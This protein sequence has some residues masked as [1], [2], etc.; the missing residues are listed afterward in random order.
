M[1]TIEQQL[2]LEQTM[3]DSG[4]SRYMKAQREAEQEG[5]GHELDYSRRLMQEFIMPL[6]EALD[7]WRNKKGASRFGRARGLLEHTS[8]EIAMFIA[9]RCMFSGFTRESSVVD[10]ANTIGKM[11]ED[12]VRFTLF[13]QQFGDY[14][15]RIIEDF[16]RKGT[17][18][19]RYMHRV[20]THK[21]NEKQLEWQPWSPV[22]RV[23]VGTKLLNIIVENSDL[24]KRVDRKYKM[25]NIV[26]LVPTDAAVKFIHEHEAI[27][28]FLYPDRAPCIIEPDPWIGVNQGGYYSAHLRQNVKAIQ[29]RHMRRIRAYAQ[30]KGKPLTEQLS[31]VFDSLNKAQSVPWEV[32]TEVLDVVRIV[33]ARNLQIGMPPTEKIEPRES[34][35]KGRDQS[36]FTEEEKMLFQEWKWEANAAYTAEKERISK[37]FQV[38]RIIKLANDYSKYNA[39]WYVWYS[40]FR[41]RLY[42]A[43]AGFSPQ[44]PDIGKGLIRFNRAKPLGT[45]EGVYWFYVHGANRYGYDKATYDNRVRWVR[46]RH[47]AFIRA[48]AD[49]L[50]HRDV[51]GSADKPWQFLAWLFEYKAMHDMV[52]LG[53]PMQQFRT[54]L[55]VGLD[56]SCNGLQNFSAMLRD[57][58]G[59]RA[60][61]LAPTEDPNDIYAE[62]AEV[63]IRKVRAKYEAATEWS[64][65]VGLDDKELEEAVREHEK[66]VLYAK[67][68]LDWGIDRKVCKRPVMTM[69]YGSTRQ[70]C[71]QYI[72]A[73]VLAKDREYFGVGHG[74]RAACWI[75][76][77]MW[78][79]IGEV[80]V[81]AR[82]AMTW[83][84]KAATSM[85][86]A[87]LPLAWTC[88]DGFIVY[89]R[90][91]EIETVQIDTQL[92]G[93]FQ[94]RVGNYTDRIDHHKQRSGV[95]PNFVHS[96]DATHLRCTI[97]KAWEYGIRDMS[98]IHDDY[99]CHA[100]DIPLLHKAIREAFVELYAN[101]DPL[102]E[103]MDEQ[104]EAGGLLQSLPAMGAFNI[105]DVLE[106]KY[107]FG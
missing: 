70:S 33:Y 42:T 51:W 11:I 67:K 106:A 76:P 75:T 78:E 37:M 54:R 32:N 71:T 20:L 52:S 84:Q 68:W 9:L 35:F 15:T 107:F 74:F 99:G 44:G 64:M 7:A 10:T 57:S 5:R 88:A 8:S 63:L 97:R 73:E 91:T 60:T 53:I 104:E 2:E 103:F 49:P 24:V 46:E 55:P 101:H 86:K 82:K 89:Q 23:D 85:N 94:A 12:E 93:R 98:L 80:V 28:R 31:D 48:A 59:A 65:P 95:A 16:K 40:D 41:G 45:R 34:I 96:Q 92:A 25:K 69:P 30:E 56:G 27:R 22:E 87:D 83:L 29:T 77:M 50:S 14:Y 18:D 39:F 3:I 58:R 81:A 102:K 6:V 61:N 36:T 105:Q 66:D 90:S 38:S 4:A 47:D 13:K 100:G 79:S 19:Y 62:V 17:K 26:E 72:F 21:A 43:T 1:S